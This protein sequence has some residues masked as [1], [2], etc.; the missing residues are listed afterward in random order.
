MD[1]IRL[2]T[3][4][5]EGESNAYVLADTVTDRL[6]IVDVGV[7]HPNTQKKF[8][9]ELEK[10]GHAIDD[11]DDILLTHFH[12]DHAGLAGS[13]QE[14]SGATVYCHP[15]TAAILE[16]N[17]S[18]L[19]EEYERYRDR[20]QTW[21]L[22]ESEC[23][24]IISLL[25]NSA[26]LAGQSIDCSTIS[27]GATLQLGSQSFDVVDLPG[28]TAGHLGYLSEANELFV[29]DVV[30]PSTTP[31][32]GGDLR[33]SNPLAAYFTSLERILLLAPRILWPGHGEA[34][35][36]ITDRISALVRHHD[37][38]FD[39]VQEQLSPAPKRPRD[40]ALSVF[41]TLDGIHLLHG[42]GEVAAHLDYLSERGAIDRVEE[43]YVMRSQSPDVARYPQA[44][45]NLLNETFE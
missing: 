12:Y 8:Q 20:L 32:I 2:D 43:G 33:A 15:K 44:L 6:T 21:G 4:V 10:L 40:I 25:T 35:R 42:T 37:H 36:D 19:I 13:I 45:A 9:R 39:R 22:K 11:I 17:T 23:N 5:F 14:E 41:G 38:R 28:H 18:A 31:N 1:R 26:S 24:D 27:G 3:V 30:L 34:I 7:H 16:L 29:G